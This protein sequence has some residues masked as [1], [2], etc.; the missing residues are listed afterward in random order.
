MRLHILIILN[1]TVVVMGRRNYFELLISLPLGT[2]TEVGLLNHVVILFLSLWGMPIF[3]YSDCINWLPSAVRKTF[4][5][6]CS[7]WISLSP[8]VPPILS[9]SLLYVIHKTGQFYWGFDLH[10]L[11]GLWC[12]PLNFTHR[13]MCILFWGSIVHVF[14]LLY[15]LCSAGIGFNFL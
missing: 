1:K 2:Y 8:I 5:P 15:F 4:F 14:C 11:H 7:H 6:P 12:W 3:F 9:F 10:F 13:P